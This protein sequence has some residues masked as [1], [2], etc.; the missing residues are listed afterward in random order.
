MLLNGLSF[1]GRIPGNNSVSVPRIPPIIAEFMSVSIGT[2]LGL[3]EI[4]ALLG[5]GGMGEVYRARDTRLKREVAI[6]ILPDEFAGDSDRVTR[7]QREAEVLASLNHP[8][9]AGIYDVQE[10]Q[11]TRF[12]ILELVEG[13]TLADRI[14]RGPIPVDEALGIA[15]QICEALEAAHEKGIIHRDLKPSNVKLTP[16]GKVKVLDFGLAKAM[17]GP[18]ANPALSNSPTLVTGSMGGM[19]VGTAAYM[20][21]EQARGRTADQR[22]DIFAFGCVLYEMLT[23]RQAFHGEDVSDILASVMKID[24]DFNHL[25]EKVNPRLTELLRRCLAKNRKERWYAVGDI[26]VEIQSILA[27]PQ[28]VDMTVRAVHMPFW[29]RAVPGVVAAVLAAGAGAAIMWIERP[30]PQP[31]RVARY[32]FYLPKDQNFTRVG[33]PT[34]AISHDG[35]RIAYVA[36]NQLYLKSLNEVEAKPIPG[37]N[38]DVSTPLFSPDGQW[39]SFFSSPERKLKKIPLAGGS[40][41]TLAENVDLPYGASW[42]STGQIVFGQAP[43]GIVRVP[44]AGGKPETLIAAKPN[45]TLDGPQLL[46]NGEVLFTVA[47]FTADSDARWDT[48]QIVV[49]NLKT[50]ERKVIV[51]SGSE[52]RYLPTGHLVYTVGATVYAVPFDT[53]KLE[54]LAGPVPVLEGVRRSGGGATG[55]AFFSLSDDGSL[56]FIPGG[57]TVDVPRVLALAD[58]SGGTKVLPLPPAGYD[59]P[60]ISPDGKHV[61]VGIRDAKDFNIWIYDL[62]GNTSM[63]RLT[64]GGRNQ[65]P[66]WTP[67]SKRIVFRSDRDGEGLYWQAADGSGVAE[68]L[69]TADKNT[70][71][72]PQEWTPDGKT[73]AFYVSSPKGGG[74]VWTLTLD[75]DRKPKPLVT[76]ATPSLSNNIRRISF[77][78]DGQWIAYASNEESTFGVYVQPYPTTGAKYKISTKNVG[79]SPIWSHDGKQLIFSSNRR[80]MVVDVQTKPAFSFSEAKQLPIEIENTQGRPYDITPDGKSFLVMQRPA[81]T[82]ATETSTPQINVVLNW[83]RELQDRVAVK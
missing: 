67:D 76:T 47:L 40:T 81:E 5:K 82:P 52:A 70:Y 59:V 12:L 51:Q 30:A 6:K 60:R 18:T 58:R 26:R 29:R 27:D 41:V 83:F 78:P 28:R 64:F 37:T 1:A 11:G 38:Q 50:G 42:S 34:I 17:E 54:V 25:P 36:N 53:R 33:R 66:A 32:S 19:I 14:V 62:E 79:D 74:S 15:V 23:G 77:S 63:R 21:P 4:T 2:Q 57:T 7:F 3:H 48:A 13:E 75:G 65:I 71:H 8:N 69:S 45:E 56:V 49:Q 22:S 80:L 35:T 10:A 46:P 55:A 16:E 20:S 44:D 43:Q 73:L 68:R 72:G 31:G 39:I 9:I 61:A 24:A